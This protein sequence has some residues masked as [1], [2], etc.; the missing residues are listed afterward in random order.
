MR[1]WLSN[2]Y[3]LGLKEFAGLASDVILVFFTV[4]WFSFMVY[5][6][7][8]GVQIE[9]QGAAVAVVD[10]DRSVLSR[11]LTDALRPPEFDPAV[12]IDRAR[13][14]AEMDAGR[15]TFVL[16]IPPGFEADL[17]RGHAPILQLNVDA[18]AISQAGTGAGYIAEI[19]N[20]E[21]A[22]YLRTRGTEAGRPVDVVIRALFNPN[23]ESLWAQSLTSL[24]D[25]ITLI[26]ILLVG[27][28]VI[29]EREHGTIE[30]LLVMPLRA[31]EIAAAKIWANGLVILAATALSLAFVIRIALQV[32]LEGSVSLFLLGTGIYLFATTSLG[33][34]LATFAK[35]MPQFGLLL[36]I[37]F[38]NMT[39]LSGATSPLET[40]PRALQLLLQISPAVH[41]VDFVQGVLFR[42]AGVDTVWPD[43]AALTVLG[44]AFTTLSL[45]R[46]RRM[47][48]DRS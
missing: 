17:L 6:E 35:S 16:D 2:S 18:T 37:V 31:S 23:S 15:F 40:M 25:K 7:A 27:A 34:L 45:I 4:Y 12:L 33:I 32:P 38:M 10:G 3:N 39:L 20:R 42:A 22:V 19:L 44:G 36:T 24:I 9:L 11:R 43:L 30:H 26:S 28:A 14:D 13:T 8:T 48:G 1:T 46:F 47:L 41:F 29:R 21:V 5:S